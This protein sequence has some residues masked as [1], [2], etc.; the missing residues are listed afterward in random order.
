M[1]ELIYK[2]LPLKRA[3]NW[4]RRKEALTTS[5]ISVAL[6]LILV[7]S[8]FFMGI[9]GLA[10]N[11]EAA[12]SSPS[13]SHPFGTDWLGRDMFVRTVKGL[14]LSFWVGLL[15]AFI[16][17]TI[18][19][20]LSLLLVLNKTMDSIVTG[21]IDLFLG[22]PHIVTLIL[23]SFMLGGGLKGVIIAVALTHWPRLARLLR[24]EI[25]QVKNTEYITVSR[26]MG[27]SWFWI[28]RHH[29][30]PH[31][32]PQ[33]FIGFILMF[34]HAILHEASITFLGFG[35]SSEQPAIGVILSEAMGYLSS[36]MWWLA[37]FPGLMLLMMVAVFDSLGRNL[38]TIFDPFKGQKE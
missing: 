17:A 1:N 2:Y 30:L 26:N 18:A 22:L 20:M 21:L 3:I 11:F 10:V 5:I 19:L 32:I 34:P 24:A 29:I 6:L 7:G 8:G 36:G 25:K 35:L 33:L 12:N 14:A 9:K 27:K 13:L 23:I 31:L 15:A 37:L 28:S 4:N 38:R 16:S